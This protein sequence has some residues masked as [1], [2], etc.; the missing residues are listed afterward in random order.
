MIKPGKQIGPLTVRKK[1][2]CAV[3]VLQLTN[4]ASAEEVHPWSN[5]ERNAEGRR[6][7]VAAKLL[8]DASHRSMNLRPN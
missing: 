2:A 4:T 8:F 7:G 3:F 1:S 6:D 5:R